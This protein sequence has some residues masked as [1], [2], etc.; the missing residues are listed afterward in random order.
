VSTSNRTER[1]RIIAREL[2]TNPEQTYTEIAQKAGIEVGNPAQTIYNRLKTENFKQVMAE[3][4]KKLYDEESL[5]N[6]LTQAIEGTKPKDAVHKGYLE[7]GMR[8][9]GMLIDR[10]INENHNFNESEL[11]KMK[12]E[13]IQE[14]INAVQAEI[15]TPNAVGERCDA[16][17]TGKCLV[18]STST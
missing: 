2:L 6:K 5:K 4:T 18:S 7:L 11:E 15:D 13:A 12:Q 10:N 1:N 17:H 16:D 14:A 3:E 9:L 8:S